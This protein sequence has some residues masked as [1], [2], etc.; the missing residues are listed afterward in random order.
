M[1]AAQPGKVY[2]PAQ[3]ETRWYATWQERGYFRPR[4]STA[5]QPFT[6]AIP[7][8]NVTGILHIGHVLNGTIQDVLVRRARMQ[9]KATLWIPGTDHASIATEAKI[10]QKLRKQGLDKRDIGRE[11]YLE[12]AWAWTEE[13]GGTI[14]EQLKRLGASAD[15]DRERFT[16][17]DGLS[18]AVRE[19]FVRLYEKGL[20][21]RGTYLVNWSPGLKT[22]VSDLEV[23]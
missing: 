21:F 6:I 2:Q 13:Y 10:V 12:E 15:W 5:A 1:S 19:A 3:V 16:L 23:E 20:I 18:R 4:E 22:A 11:K 14:I 7:P 17:D 8:P 9:G